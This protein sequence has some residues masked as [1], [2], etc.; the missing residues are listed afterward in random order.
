MSQH[1]H[2]HFRRLDIAREALD[3]GA[4]RSVVQQITGISEAELRRVFGACPA[5]TTNRGGRPSSVDKLFQ[6]REIHLHA[7]DFYNG[8]HHVFH[9]GVPP[10]ESMVVAYRRYLGRHSGDVRLGFDRAFSV[11]TSVCR[12][13]TSTA[14]LL[15]PVR[16]NTCDALFLAPVGASAADETP[17]TYCKVARRLNRRERVGSS[18][19]SHSAMESAAMYL[20]SL[21]G[22]AATVNR[23]GA[24][25]AHETAQA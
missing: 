6:G 1:T 10:D 2:H 20:G 25:P 24:V 16:C 14:P 13:W 11:V 9:R 15:K 22:A 3:L 12:L 23:A 19:E 7:S 17:C 4:R 5:L 18:G 8:F 21:S